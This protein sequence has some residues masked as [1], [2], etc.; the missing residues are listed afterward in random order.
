MIWKDMS[1]HFMIVLNHK[2]ALFVIISFLKKG[3][4]KHIKS[5]HDKKSNTNA[6]FVLYVPLETITYKLTL[7][8][9]MNRKSSTSAKFVNTDFLTNVVKKT[10]QIRP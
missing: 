5:V 6:L 9:Y 10:C 7:N 3:N 8:L 1:N 4:L 2:N